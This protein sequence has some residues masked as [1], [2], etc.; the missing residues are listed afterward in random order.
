MLARPVQGLSRGRRVDHERGRGDDTALVSLDDT[1]VDARAKAKVVRGDDESPHGG[2]FYRI[3][4]MRNAFSVFLCLGVA[5]SSGNLLYL[6]ALFCI[7]DSGQ[8]RHGIIR[9]GRPH[10]T[11]D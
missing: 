8:P 5:A 6:G 7:E 1:R 3:F 11:E 10:D 2:R 9:P 4:S